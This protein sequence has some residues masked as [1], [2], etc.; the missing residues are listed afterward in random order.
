MKK[1]AKTSC[2][3]GRRKVKMKQFKKQSM[4]SRVLDGETIEFMEWLSPGFAQYYR[5]S[6]DSEG[7]YIGQKIPGLFG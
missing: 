3:F 5:E 6:Y 7:N 1:T 2:K 4:R